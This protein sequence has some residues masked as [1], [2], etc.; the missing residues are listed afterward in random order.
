MSGSQRS[1]SRRRRRQVSEEER[2]A[3]VGDYRES[4]DRLQ[5]T[6]YRNLRQSVAYAT[7]FVAVTATWMLFIGQATPASFLWYGVAI[8]SGAFGLATYV[9]REPRARLYVLAVAV[10]LAVVGVTG[11][12]LAD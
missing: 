10:A 3:A 7:I 5:H 1:G 11:I 12:F 2:A 6:A 9:V 4:V 8:L